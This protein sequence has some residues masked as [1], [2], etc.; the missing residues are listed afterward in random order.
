[1]PLRASYTQVE[2]ATQDSPTPVICWVPRTPAT[3]YVGMCVNV[4]DP[5]WWFVTRLLGTPQRHALSPTTSRD[6]RPLR[7]YPL[8][9]TV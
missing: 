8:M 9:G 1:M 5:H 3:P 2:I 7:P 6:R 4:G